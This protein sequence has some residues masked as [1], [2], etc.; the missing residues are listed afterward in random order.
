MSVTRERDADLVGGQEPLETVRPLQVRVRSLCLLVGVQRIV[1]EREFQ[2]T[3]VGREIGG[4]PLILGAGRTPMRRVVVGIDGAGA[5]VAV[6]PVGLQ[7]VE[8]RGSGI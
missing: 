1:K 4:Q 7:Y 3:G 5:D 8:A 6:G 2:P